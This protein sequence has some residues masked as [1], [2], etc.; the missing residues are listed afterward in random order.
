M[1]F[2]SGFLSLALAATPQN[3]DLTALDGSTISA[4]TLETNAI[5]F[6]NVASKCGY[7]PQYEGLEKLYQDYKDKGL[8]VI[9]VPCNQF[10]KQEPGTAEEIQTFCKLNYGVSFP[11][12]EKQDVNGKN[13]S[14]LYSQLIT[15]NKDIRWN[16]E[17]ILVDQKGAVI[18]R[19]P[20]NVAPESPELRQAIDAVLQK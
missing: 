13:R 8:V 9:G 16:F 14:S 18:A 4:K 6:V 15:D 3:M 17:K 1:T 12:L 10:G 7:T 2:L 19:F 11:L 20:S 5:L